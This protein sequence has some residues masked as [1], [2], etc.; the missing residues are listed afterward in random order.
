VEGDEGVKC[1]LYVAIGMALRRTLTVVPDGRH[2]IKPSFVGN[3]ICLGCI[4]NQVPAGCE[5]HLHPL[6]T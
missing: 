4:G 2:K 1:P 5:L 6:P 3:H